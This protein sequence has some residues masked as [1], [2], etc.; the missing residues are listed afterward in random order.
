M[1]GSDTKTFGDGATLDDMGEWF[2]PRSRFLIDPPPQ[3]ATDYQD[4]MT[5]LV[6]D[7]D[8]PLFG[9]RGGH[10]QHIYT[11]SEAPDVVAMLFWELQQKGTRP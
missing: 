11:Y 6:G 1:L 4:D 10:G 8:K 2:M 9:T 7:S 5:F 3:D